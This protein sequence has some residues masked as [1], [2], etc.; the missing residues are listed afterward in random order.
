MSEA[1]D[2]DVV[3]VVYEDGK[4]VTITTDKDKAQKDYDDRSGK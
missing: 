1:N 2:G 4:P 3:Y